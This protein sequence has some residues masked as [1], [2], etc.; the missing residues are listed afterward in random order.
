VSADAELRDAVLLER[1]GRIAEAI[2]VYERVL[3]RWPDR[4]D[5]WCNLALL[6]R[7]ARRYEAALASYQHALDHGVSQPAEVHLRRSVIYA[8]CLRRDAAADAELNAALAINPRHVPALLNLANRDE[9]L[10]RR[11]QARARYERILE[12]DPLCHLALTRLAGLAS[13][14]VVADPL[15]GQ[16]RAAIARTDTSAADG[17]SLGLA[18][19]RVLDAGGAY[20]D[21]FEAYREANR[22]SRGSASRGAPYDRQAQ[23]RFVDELIESFPAAR[24]DLPWAESAVRPIFI[25]GMFR[26]GLTV[27]EQLLAEHRQVVAGG[28]IDLL[29]ALARTEIRPYP[30]SMPRIPAASLAEMG[31]WYLGS[32][33]SLFPGAEYV[34]DKRP[35]NFLHIGLIKTL[36]PNARIV[37]T[38]RNP[39]DNCL[40]VYFLYVDH[41]MSY[42][43]DL[44]DTGHY[45]RQYRRLMAHWCS[46]YGPDIC[47]FDYDTYVREPAS[48]AQ[49]LF[50]FCGLEPPGDL[51][52]RA[53]A[54][55]VRT[56]GDWQVRQPPYRSSSGRWRNY[57]RQLGTLEAELADLVSEGQQH[58]KR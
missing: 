15:I 46:L 28:E 20:E 34:T 13:E 25:C 49:R 51:S 11:E 24:R 39:L 5:S 38:T 30:S 17:A 14:A 32:L 57:A 54:G 8:D 3:S 37:H 26:S 47:D 27:T 6:Q 1:G 23:E 18:L 52:A 7:K 35:D 9:D 31:N 12:I 33:A 45:Y 53:P 22:Q 19:G 56:A 58:P 16:L 36:F 44:L 10:G 2:S 43:L 42:A 4:P 41:G 55:A 29:P 21:A 48:S 40:S 50:E